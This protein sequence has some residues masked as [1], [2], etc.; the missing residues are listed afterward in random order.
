[1]KYI[2]VRIDDEVYLNARRKAAAH[3]TSVNQLIADY[4]SSLSDEEK[5]RAE[6]NKRLEELF[7]SQDRG[8]R[9][10]PVGRIQRKEIYRPR[11][12]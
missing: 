11:D 10:K 5:L 1:M 8:P 2:V 4:L 6:R 12:Y 7:D 3:N 9:T